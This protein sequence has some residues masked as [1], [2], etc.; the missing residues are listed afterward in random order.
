MP[1]Q[2]RL[3]VEN[4]EQLKERIEREFGPTA[5]IA[6]AERVSQGG[7]GKFMA[8][9][10]IEAI[11]E[12]PDDDPAVP[13]APA[14]LRRAAKTAAE[15]RGA[16]APAGKLATVVPTPIKPSTIKPGTDPGSGMGALLERADAQEELLAAPS[17]VRRRPAGTDASAPSGG[18]EKPGGGAG[19]FMRLLDGESFAFE[20]AKGARAAGPAAGPAARSD[21]TSPAPRTSGQAPVRVA[22]AAVPPGTI[23]SGTIPSDADPYRATGSRGPSHRDILPSPLDGPGDLVVVVGLWG[24]GVIAGAQLGAESA[25]RRQAGELAPKFNTDAA[26]R[27]PLTDRRGVLKARAAAVEAQEPL[28]VSVA[29]NPLQPLREQM[30]LLDTLGPDQLWVAVDAGRKSEDTAAWVKHVSARHRVYAVVA[31]HGNETLS[32]ESVLE[33][34]FP[35]FDVTAP[36]P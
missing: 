30:E 10:Y 17:G 28:V 5:R 21:R 18:S 32:P 25:M 4:L 8:R 20:P 36:T 6:S 24:D 11:V 34:G 14:V 16:T 3:E 13:P 15:V 33:L 1:T 31:L 19:E 23:Q 9:R 12:V 26:V 29:L 35:V 2:Y 27:Q 22:P 7:I